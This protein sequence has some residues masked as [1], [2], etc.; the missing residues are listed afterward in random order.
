[1]AGSAVGVGFGHRGSNNVPGIHLNGRFGEHRG[2]DEPDGT[3]KKKIV[4]ISSA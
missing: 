1:M 4:S 3:M 2:S